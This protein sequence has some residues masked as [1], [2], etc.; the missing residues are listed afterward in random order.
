MLF[1]FK[2]RLPDFLGRSCD[3]LGLKIWNLAFWPKGH[4]FRLAGENGEEG[5]ADDYGKFISDHIYCF[6]KGC[7]FEKN[8]S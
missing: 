2:F 8:E 1:A 3:L 6:K 4:S 7:S 5:K